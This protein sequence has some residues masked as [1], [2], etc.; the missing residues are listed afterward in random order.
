MGTAVRQ[1]DVV[2]LAAVLLGVGV[3]DG[4]AAYRPGELSFEVLQSDVDLDAITIDISAQTSNLPQALAVLA[5]V[6]LA[7]DAAAAAVEYRYRTQNEPN[8]D[9]DTGWV[10]SL[11]RELGPD[12]GWDLEVV[13][14]SSGSIKATL[15]KILSSSQDRRKIL[16]VAG[17]AAAVAGVIISGPAAAPGLIIAV[18]GIG[19]AFFPA[20]APPAPEAV[21]QL[22]RAQGAP[23]EQVA[24]LQADNREL[25]EEL[26]R[27]KLESVDNVAALAAQ[28]EQLTL[29]VANLQPT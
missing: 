8:H 27:V 10:V 1:D 14:L 4:A 18:L 21:A 11:L 5:A 2:N 23:N 12:F 28:V 24:Q 29:T 7:V 26:A 6:Q 15:R 3:T 13:E 25:A 20:S 16:A 19:D 17:L 9:D 22:A